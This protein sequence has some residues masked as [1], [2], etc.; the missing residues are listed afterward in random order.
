[1]SSR[2]RSCRWRFHRFTSASIPVLGRPCARSTATL[3]FH[4]LSPYQRACSTSTVPPPAAAAEALP[5]DTSLEVVIVLRVGFP[6]HVEAKTHV[7]SCTRSGVNNISRGRITLSGGRGP[8][9]DELQSNDRDRDDRQTD[10]SQERDRRAR[11]IIGAGRV[12]G[13]G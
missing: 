6:R 11:G 1:M 4:T 13:Q 10:R 5:D 8:T 2:R 3:G 7:P 12:I 9:A